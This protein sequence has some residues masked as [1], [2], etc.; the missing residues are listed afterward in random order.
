MLCAAGKYNAVAGASVCTDCPAGHYNTPSTPPVVGD[1]DALDDCI[2]CVAGKISPAGSTVVTACVDCAAGKF[3]A[4]TSSTKCTDCVAG[5]YSAA[6]A[7]SCTDCP[8]NAGTGT[9]TGST[10]QTACGCNAG[11]YGNPTGAGSAVTCTTCANGKYKVWEAGATLVE[12][13]LD[14]AAGKSGT[15]TIASCTTCVAGKYSAAAAASCTDCPTNAGTG[16]NTGST[17]QTAC[18]CN[19]GYY[20]N[21]TGANTAVDCTACANGKYKVWEAGA[22]LVA[23]CL[24]CAEGKFSASGASVCTDCH[25]GTYTDGTGKAA[26]S[27]CYFCLDGMAGSLKASFINDAATTSAGTAPQACGGKASMC[28][29]NVTAFTEAAFD[30]FLTCKA[31]TTSCVAN[32]VLSGT[33]SSATCVDGTRMD[34][35][36]DVTLYM[37]MTQFT[38]KEGDFVDAVAT[39]LGVTDKAK[40]STKAAE[41]SVQEADLGYYHWL[42]TTSGTKKTKV[43]TTVNLDAPK[44]FNPT[45]LKA[46]LTTESVTSSNGEGSV[47]A[48]GVPTYTKIT[49][50]LTAATAKGKVEVTLTFDAELNAM[51]QV[52]VRMAVAVTAGVPVDNVVMAEARRRSVQYKITVYTDSASAATT[53]AGKLTETALKAEI[54]TQGGPAPTAVGTATASKTTTAA[55]AAGNSTAGGLSAANRAAPVPVAIAFLVSSVV[56]AVFSA[57]N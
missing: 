53:I 35:A 30:Q 55:A 8:A 42:G 29:A 45:D 40:V 28:P 37:T 11:Y 44:S 12:K 10:A 3:R 47:L 4:D 20:G 2:G 15:G 36:F 48:V 56:A 14:C 46:K 19:A 50:I 27:S 18:G 1:F 24:D 32:K 5:K 31:V 41:S 52:K 38:A 9:N 49:G 39:S 23:K 17:A 43:T 57:V 21:P 7:A 33:G 26:S 13:C 6:A 54:A 16:T 34:M 51:Q 25:V 22:T